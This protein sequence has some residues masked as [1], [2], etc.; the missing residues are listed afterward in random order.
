MRNI[1]FKDIK[2]IIRFST[3]YLLDSLISHFS[4]WGAG[5]LAFFSSF[6]QYYQSDFFRNI[7]NNERLPNAEGLYPIGE[8]HCDV[9][10]VFK[11]AGFFN[12]LYGF[13]DLGRVTCE[14]ALIQPMDYCPDGTVQHIDANTSAAA[15]VDCL[16]PMY[17]GNEAITEERVATAI[18]VTIAMSIGLMIF[19]YWDRSRDTIAELKD[20]SFNILHMLYEMFIALFKGCTRCCITYE[21]P[22]LSEQAYVARAYAST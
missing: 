14:R 16:P 17:H 3:G 22:D 7:I 4:I 5:S 20:I 9:A 6:Y 13:L 12:F 18:I 15:I 10:R 11:P 19:S 1:E 2:N 21:E 8:V